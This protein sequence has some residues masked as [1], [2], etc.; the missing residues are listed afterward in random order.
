MG[1]PSSLTNFVDRIRSGAIAHASN[2]DAPKDRPI[3][4]VA[5]SSSSPSRVVDPA[6]SDERGRSKTRSHERNLDSTANTALHTPLHDAEKSIPL[7]DSSTSSN[8]QAPGP[9]PPAIEE[10]GPPDKRSITTRMKQG[11][12]R[13]GRH[14]KVAIFHSWVNLLLVFVPIGIAAKCAHLS[15]GI[16]FAMNAIAIIP[17]A[18]ILTHATESVASRL[19]DTL[20]ALLN[21]SFGNAVE[22]I[23][24]MYVPTR[25]SCDKDQLHRA[26]LN[27]MAN[28]KT[29]AFRDILLTYSLFHRI[30]LPL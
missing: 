9:E 14:T 17:L 30:A 2:R 3:L 25:M 16:V 24:F 26:S 11:A 5:Q 20:G 27:E 21:V 10:P 29:F 23:I 19:G 4:P 6:H 1:K 7:V 15:P 13:F 22:L 8:T 18:G 28:L 12:L